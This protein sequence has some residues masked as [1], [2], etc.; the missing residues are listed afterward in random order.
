MATRLTHVAFDIETTGLDAE[1]RVT[2]AGFALPLGCRVFV[3]ASAGPLDSSRVESHLDDRLDTTIELSDHPG[4]GPLLDSVGTF[5]AERV[6]PREYLLVAYNGDRF[7]GGFD[8]PFLRTRYA[9][10]SLQWPFDGIPFADLMPIISNRFNSTVDGEARNDLV[11]A[12]ETLIGGDH[13]SVDPFVESAEAV[14]A[15]EAGEFEPLVAHNV[16]DI[17]RTQALS[18]LAQRFCGTSEFSLKSLTP[19]SRDPSLSDPE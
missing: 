13:S 11:G 17:R 9:S 12:Y 16:A 15:F 14:R 10:H 18:S 7:A 6:A 19:A 2:V 8:L 1:D 4:E 3:N 5:L